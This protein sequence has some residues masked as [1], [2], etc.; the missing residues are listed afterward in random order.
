MKILK[1]VCI[2]LIVFASNSIFGQKTSIGLSLRSTPYS[3]KNVR[4][5]QIKSNFT[6]RS[7]FVVGLGRSYGEVGQNIV[8]S[9]RLGYRYKLIDSKRFD[10]EIG[11]TYNPNSV[12]TR[13]GSLNNGYI[14][15]DLII[16][17]SF[18]FDITNRIS[19][20]GDVGYGR[21]ITDVFTVSPGFEQNSFRGGLGLS[22]NLMK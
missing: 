15:N 17:L 21:Q 1:I 7:S 2:L 22:F 10:A 18:S 19:I 14:S 4:E 16:P 5:F 8:F 20:F 11:L 6:K 9:G 13:T 12:I 3:V